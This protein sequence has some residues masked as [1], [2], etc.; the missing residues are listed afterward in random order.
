ML[1]TFIHIIVVKLIQ[2][3]FSDV[4]RGRIG[5]IGT[6]RMGRHGPELIS[7]SA[8][9]T[10]DPSERQ[11]R[12]RACFLNARIAWLAIVPQRA[13][14]GGKWRLK[15]IPHWPNFWRTWLEDHPECLQ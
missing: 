11:I 3:L 7:I 13:Y 5:D 12:L 8:G 10:C 15:R 9:P 2:P 14:E 1:L 6:F 4:A